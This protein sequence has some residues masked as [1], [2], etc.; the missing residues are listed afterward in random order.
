MRQHVPPEQ[1][2][3]EFHGDLEFEYDHAEYWPA[4]LSL[5]E[6][7]QAEHRER[8]VQAGKHLGESEIFIRGGNVPSVGARQIITQENSVAVPLE[9]TKD[10]PGMTPDGAETES[11]IQPHESQANGNS[12]IATKVTTPTLTSEGDRQ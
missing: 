10:T 4:L 6:K 11:P 3:N 7:K 5:C 9:K 8:W 12:S 2:W 1:L